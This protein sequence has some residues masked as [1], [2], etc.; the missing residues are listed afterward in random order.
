[1]I[2][3]MI[4]KIEEMTGGMTKE[5]KNVMIAEERRKRMTEETEKEIKIEEAQNTKMM[6]MIVMRYVA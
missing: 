1:M 6:M 4:R 2:I 5:M 3:K